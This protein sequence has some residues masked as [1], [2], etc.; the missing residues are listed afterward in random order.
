MG[1]SGNSGQ[2]EVKS[3]LNSIVDISERWMIFL[4][5]RRN[6]V[7]IVQSILVGF[8][9]W[10]VLLASAIAYFLAQYQYD[11]RNFIKHTHNIFPVFGSVFLLGIAGI[12][13]TYLLLGRKKDP[14]L[15]ELSSLIYEFK[16]NNQTQGSANAYLLADRIITL[17]PNVVRKR[18][19]DALLFGAFAFLIALIIAHLDVAILVGVGIWL[20]FRYEMNRNYEREMSKFEEQKRIFEQRKK[21]FIDSL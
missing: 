2:D 11:I 17:L 7:R 12:I 4:R 10:I 13:L 20:Y 16:K 3:S 9:V 18:D 1:P 19:G 21:E 15:Q 14:Q 6:R 8:L 5:R